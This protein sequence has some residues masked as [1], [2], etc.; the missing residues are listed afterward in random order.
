MNC[1]MKIQKII[2]WMTCIVVAPILGVVLALCSCDFGCV[3][4]SKRFPYVSTKT[5]AHEGG[6]EYYA[7]DEAGRVY[8]GKDGVVPVFFCKYGNM[9]AVN[10]AMLEKPGLWKT[11]NKVVVLT[12]DE[13]DSPH[14]AHSECLIVV[15]DADAGEMSVARPTAADLQAMGNMRRIEVK[16]RVVSCYDEAGTCHEIRVQVQHRNNFLERIWSWCLISSV[17]K[18]ER[19]YEKGGCKKWVDTETGL[20]WAYNEFDGGV[21]IENSRTRGCAVSPMP[22]GVAVIPAYINGKPVK[23]IG[24]NVIVNCDV[25]TV[26]IPRTV[27]RFSERAPFSFT[28]YRLCRIEVED[29]NRMFQSRAGLLYD[30]TGKV[31]LCV[32]PNVSDIQIPEGVTNIADS[33]FDHCYPIESVTIPA[34]VKVLG[35]WVFSMSSV[36]KVRFLGDAPAVPTTTMKG[37]YS[38]TPTSLTTYA[39]KDALGWREDGK[40]PTTWCERPIVFE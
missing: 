4:S 24:D 26:R 29:G 16:G 23:C 32:P 10:V 19:S 37:I 15:M 34:S 2:I 36:K 13:G 3:Y 25:A 20:E 5:E 22:K 27:E 7:T 8:T 12:G 1:T 21:I 35:E 33:A 30:I 38:M 11:G 18:R 40:L 17:V 31:L 28:S 6:I 39:R 14:K 9:I